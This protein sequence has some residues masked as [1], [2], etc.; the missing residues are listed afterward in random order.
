MSDFEK[1]LVAEISLILGI[2]MEE[3]LPEA[4]L[5]DLGMDSLSFV[6]LLVIIE[7]K[8]GLKLMET[9]LTREDF[10]TIESLARCI[11]KLKSC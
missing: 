2:E 5:Q 11:E 9:S 7:K 8:F 1:Q 10:Q 4:P 3:V 6:E